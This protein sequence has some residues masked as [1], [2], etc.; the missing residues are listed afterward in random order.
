[1]SI[2][3]GFMW[4][5]LCVVEVGVAG[6]RCPNHSNVIEAGWVRQENSPARASL[7]EHSR[8]SW[9]CSLGIALLGRESNP[10]RAILGKH[11]HCN[12]PKCAIL[13]SNLRRAFPRGHAQESTLKRAVP[14]A[15]LKESSSRRAMLREQVQGNTREQSQKSIP[16]RAMSGKPPQ[17][18]NSQTARQPTAAI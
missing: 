7:G 2:A 5:S 17:E 12:S 6:M 9:D 10:K 14:R 15:K 3:F 13:A 11:L 16:K 18:S 8:D 1:M 4:V